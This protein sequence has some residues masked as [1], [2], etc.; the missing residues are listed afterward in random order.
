MKVSINDLKKIQETAQAGVNLRNGNP[1]QSAERFH[2]LICAGTACVS[3]GSSKLR[4]RLVKEIETRDLGTKVKVV[5]TGCNGFCA[6]GPIMVVYP[7]RIFY[8]KL[9]PEDVPRIVQEHLIDG[10]PVVDFLYKDLAGKKLLP[11]CR[12]FLSSTDRSFACYATAPSL[13]PKILTNTLLETAIWH[14]TRR[15]TP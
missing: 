14:F 11:A 13:I 10:R 2:L 12:T 1:A 6:E 3:C 9:K 4:E 8:H 7:E 5:I 15:L